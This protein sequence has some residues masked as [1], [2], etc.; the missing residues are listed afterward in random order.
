M[1]ELSVARIDA[2]RERNVSVIGLHIIHILFA[3]SQQIGRYGVRIEQIQHLHSLHGIFRAGV[4][5]PVHAIDCAGVHEIVQ[6]LENDQFLS[7]L[8][9]QRGFAGFPASERRDGKCPYQ[10]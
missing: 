5:A 3:P 6:D 4:D 8:A 7:G 10:P 1:A 9:R 2:F